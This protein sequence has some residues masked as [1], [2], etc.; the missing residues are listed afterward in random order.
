M[1]LSDMIDDDLLDQMIRDGMIKQQTHPLYPYAIFNYTPKAVYSKTWNAATLASRGLIV[2]LSTSEVVARPFAKFFNWDQPEVGRLPIGASIVAPKMDGSLGVLYSG[3]YGG[4][5]IATRGSFTSP[6]AVRATKMLHRIIDDSSGLYDDFSPHA[7]YLFEIIYPE[8]RI[9]CDYGDD[10]RLVLLDVIDNETG[11]SD[12]AEFDTVEWPDKVERRAVHIADH[13]ADTLH[14]ILDEVP[15]DEEGL[16]FYFPERDL[17]FKMKKAEYMRLH[18]IVTGVST[19]TIWQTL[20][21][22]GDF[23][24]LLDRVPDEFYSWVKKTVA[25]FREMHRIVRHGA[26][27]DYQ[28]VR[29]G[30]PVDFT[31]KDFALYVNKHY[32]HKQAYMFALLDGR[33]ID[34][35]AW[36]DIKPTYEKPFAQITEDNN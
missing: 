5:H 23:E 17:R 21:S 14:A 12:L 19:K 24:E 29:A 25:D 6:Q 34:E 3:P 15:E 9:V 16:V 2:D 13:N 33:S 8:N 28:N 32:R 36:A 31:R 18:R 11:K 26:L 30:L 35:L 4:L 1:Q 10:E 7:T 20:A 27:A 22:R